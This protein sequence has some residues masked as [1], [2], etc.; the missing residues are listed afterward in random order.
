MDS[1]VRRDLVEVDSAV[2]LHVVLGVDLQVF[3]GVDRHQHRTDVRLAE[4]GTRGHL[5]ITFG[6]VA[7]FLLNPDVPDE[8]SDGKQWMLLRN[9]R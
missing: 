8:F 7:H 4:K 6:N 3:V 5:E 9:N 1:H 2:S